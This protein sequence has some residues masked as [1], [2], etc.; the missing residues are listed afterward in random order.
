[1]LHGHERVESKGNFS[2]VRNF[3]SFPRP[4][5]PPSSSSFLSSSS[6]P[7]S[8]SSSSSSSSH[9][10]HHHVSFQ[11]L[12]HEQPLSRRKSDRTAVHTTT[13]RSPDRPRPSPRPPGPLH[14]L[15][16]QNV[17]AGHS[18]H[19]PPRPHKLPRCVSLS[20][21]PPRAQL[22]PLHR[23]L[24]RTLR[25]LPRAR[26]GLR[27]CPTQGPPLGHGPANRAAHGQDPC[28]SARGGIY[29]SKG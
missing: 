20:P 10:E 26:P 13:N 22:T 27:A 9:K 5:P 6:A 15:H 1:M 7:S 25:P 11:P 14:S 23:Y 21:F 18:R 17:R 16:S 29:P 2:P 3:T 4:L 12:H 24:P 19:L 28:K 8:S